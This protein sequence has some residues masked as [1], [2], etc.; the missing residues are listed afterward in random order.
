MWGPDIPVVPPQIA[1]RWFSIAVLGFVSLGVLC[2]YAH[3][4]IPAIRREY[5]FDG[6]SSELGGLEENKVSSRAP[7]FPLR[8]SVLTPCCR[9]GWRGTLRAGR[10]SLIACPLKQ[11]SV[12]VRPVFSSPCF[13]F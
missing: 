5:P 9:R 1:L 2:N 4:V 6:L 7:R 3:P 11:W 8:A 13:S 12:S 10:F